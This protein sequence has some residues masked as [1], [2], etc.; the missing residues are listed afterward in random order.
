MLRSLV[1][2]WSQTIFIWQNP[3]SDDEIDDEYMYVKK[4]I[5]DKKLEMYESNQFN[6]THLPQMN[7]HFD[8]Y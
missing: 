5:D 1:F 3:S 8:E 4:L 6:I 7:E 2:I